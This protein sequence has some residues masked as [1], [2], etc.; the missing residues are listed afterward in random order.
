MA[1]LKF[2]IFS[3]PGILERISEHSLV[4]SLWQNTLRNLACC[5]DFYY[6]DTKSPTL[7]STS[8]LVNSAQHVLPTSIS[9]AEVNNKIKA[10]QPNDELWVA[11]M[12]KVTVSWTSWRTELYCPGP[13]FVREVSTL[14]SCLGNMGKA[15]KDSLARGCRLFVGPETYFHN[16]TLRDPQP[17]SADEKLQLDEA[18][19]KLTA[20][21]DMA[22]VIAGT[23]YWVD[24]EK[25][26]HNSLLAF[27]GGVNLCTGATAYDKKEWTGEEQ[28][29]GRAVGT[30]V[31]GE[32]NFTKI[33]WQTLTVL[34][35]ICQDSAPDAQVRLEP[36]D[37]HIIVGNG[38][39]ALSLKQRPGGVGAY[40]DAQGKGRF[41]DAFNIHDVGS[42][43][44]AC[45]LSLAWRPALVKGL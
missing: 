5:F 26:V 29:A 15:I 2:F 9:P 20:D 18:M 22:L 30:P 39:G 44:H 19:Q 14:D 12:P 40:A 23:V 41:Q 31:I 37:I 36:C 17:L 6:F 1:R 28:E 34:V 21:F 27:S 16:G 33:S 7:P 25:R 38:T 10:M 11:A 24:A 35:Q 4:T 42:G 32:K 3:D 45:Q 43:H 13:G 8:A